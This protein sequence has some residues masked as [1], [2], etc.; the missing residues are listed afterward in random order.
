LALAGGGGAGV[1]KISSRITLEKRE[2]LGTNPE[3]MPPN[4]GQHMKKKTLNRGKTTG[5]GK[6]KIQKGS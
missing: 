2:V 4:L 5:I 1:A 3:G 6:R